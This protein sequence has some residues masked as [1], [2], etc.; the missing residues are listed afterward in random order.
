MTEERRCPCC[1]GTLDSHREGCE[2][3]K[4][5]TKEDWQRFGEEMEAR[6]YRQAHQW[7]R[8]IQ[9]IEERKKLKEGS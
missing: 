4:P 8:L 2:L 6:V 9:F 3:A 1:E 5:M 7:D